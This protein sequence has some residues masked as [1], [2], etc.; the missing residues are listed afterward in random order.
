[1]VARGEQDAEK[2]ALP[3]V[4]RRSPSVVVVRSAI[5]MSMKKIKS[6]VEAKKT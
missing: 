2:G 4:R 1:M 5:L 6:D 3:F